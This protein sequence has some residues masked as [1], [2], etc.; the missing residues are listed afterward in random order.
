M[1]Y[2]IFV[3][4]YLAVSITFGQDM[5]AG[6]KQ[7]E[8]GNFEE[9]EKFF[10]KVLKEHPTNKTAQLCYGRAVGLSGNPS[11]GK[12]IFQNLLKQYPNDFELKLNYAESLLWN[13]EFKNAEPYYLSLVK[14]KPTNF[15]ARLGYAN[16]LSNLDEFEKAL[17]EVNKAI[18]IEDNQNARISRKYIRLGFA[19][20]LSTSEKYEEAEKLL[21]QNLNENPS[22]LDSSVSL[23][24]LY[25]IQEKIE[26]AATVFSAITDSTQ[27]YIGQSL[28]A[29]K[30]KK[31]KKAL[32]FAK[33]AL[34]FSKNSDSTINFKAKER[35]IQA[36]I[37]NGKYK[38]AQQQIDTLQDEY[39]M[40][41]IA[42]I[43]AMLG[44]YTAKFNVSEAQYLAI[45]KVDSASFDGNLGIANTFRAK[46]ELIKALAY[47]KNTLLF[48][49]NQK[50]AK[51]LV[52][53]IENTLAPKVTS[54]IV[55]TQDNGNNTAFAYAVNAIVPIS[56]RLKLKAGYHKR[57]TENTNLKLNATNTNLSGGL[58]YRVVNNTWLQ[59]EVSLATIDV[60][61]EISNTFNG[62]LFFTSRPFPNHYLKAGFKRELQDFNSQLLAEKI[63]LNNFIF[64]YNFGTNFGLGWYT[65]FTH[66]TQ[67]D[68]NTRNVLFTSLYYNF[69]KNPTL[70][71]GLNYQY[72]GFKEQM[73]ELYFS[74]SKYQAVE[75]FAEIARN[76]KKLNYSLSGAAGYQFVE[77][78]PKTSL[79]RG[80]AK[81]Q[82]NFSE[83]SSLEAYGK[84][85]NIASETATGF[86]FTE[87]GIKWV[88]QITK[89]PLFTMD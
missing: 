84:Y 34:E 73:P 23:A 4:L 39:G 14:Q 53:T 10:A 18:A 87:V 9:A 75:V 54:K 41:P 66:T 72:L 36:L 68:N 22:D 89:K 59:S 50:D 80:E 37:W 42:S 46:G 48:Y 28:V 83:R 32:V 55:Y 7:L 30:L 38:Q 24:N 33:K 76:G 47:A 79:L 5:N 19:N 65:G 77:N 8:I 71:G 40:L 58:D 31:E 27:A 62:S 61:G 88:W 74:P 11:E 35:Y 25:I 44:M 69:L 29:H 20:Q 2:L 21:L 60:N 63:S 1:K 56:E 6:F 49:P 67:S 15:A 26:N 82:Y 12:L 85:S 86:R 45:L 52:E 13:K 78:A 16:T 64:N 51:K 43:Q 17:A 70:K 81:I 3:L 57:T